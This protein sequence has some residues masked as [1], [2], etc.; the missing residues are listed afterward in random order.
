M[1]FWFVNHEDDEVDKKSNHD[2]KEPRDNQ[3]MTAR[4]R[5]SSGCHRLK[6][7]AGLPRHPKYD[8]V[9]ARSKTLVDT[10]DP[11]LAHSSKCWFGP[12]VVGST[13]HPAFHNRIQTMKGYHHEQ[14]WGDD[15]KDWILLP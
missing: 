6:S 5:E 8:F 14:W 4:Q 2:W 11:E 12:S 10:T 3:T 1:I 15:T 7:T 9:V 13:K